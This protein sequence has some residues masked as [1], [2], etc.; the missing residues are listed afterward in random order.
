M[1]LYEINK[2]FQQ[3]RD[4]FFNGNTH[5]FLQMFVL[6]LPYTTL[7]YSFHPLILPQLRSNFYKVRGNLNKYHLRT[8]L[9]VKIKYYGNKGH[10]HCMN[11]TPSDYINMNVSVNTGFSQRSYT[12]WLCQCLAVLSPDIVCLHSFNDNISKFS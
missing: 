11:Y 6:S 9:R 3:H 2:L 7:R 1:L 12:V 5:I 8:G 4:F 10:K